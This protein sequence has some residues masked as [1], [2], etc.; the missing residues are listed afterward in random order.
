MEIKQQKLAD[1]SKE[2]V[3]TVAIEIVD[4]VMFSHSKYDVAAHDGGDFQT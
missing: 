2:T 1:G 3:S 4:T